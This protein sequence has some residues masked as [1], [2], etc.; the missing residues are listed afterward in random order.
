M[1]TYRDS[2]LLLVDDDHGFR[3]LMRYELEKEGYA[4]I[5]EAEDGDEALNL[6]REKHIDLLLLD[7]RMPRLQ[8]EEV[9]RVVKENY[10]SIPVIVVT[11]RTESEIKNSVLDLGAQ[12]YLEKPYNSAE[13]FSTIT[14]A[15]ESKERAK[16]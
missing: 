10:P 16:G 5:L 15:L 6:I 9:L 7:L 11:G 3:Q 1:A 4:S 2:T 14:K 8:G 13:L 12:A